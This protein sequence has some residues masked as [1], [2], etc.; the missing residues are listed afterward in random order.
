VT[1]RTEI[2]EAVKKLS[3][4]CGYPPTIRELCDHCGVSSTATVHHHLVNLRNAGLLAFD[5]K[6]SRTVRVL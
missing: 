1:S 2:L 4:E 6:K 5:E 3:N